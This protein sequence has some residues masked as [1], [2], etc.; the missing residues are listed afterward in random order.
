MIL[1]FLLVRAGNKGA[2]YRGYI[3]IMFP[4][5]LLRTSKPVYGISQHD[6]GRISLH[7]V[8]SLHEPDPSGC[9]L[10]RPERHAKPAQNLANNRKKNKFSK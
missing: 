6:L 1:L 10:Q 8:R 9:S 4:Y 3:G 7:S 5:S 2:L